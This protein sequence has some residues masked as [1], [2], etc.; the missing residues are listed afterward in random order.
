MVAQ[1]AAEQTGVQFLPIVVGVRRGLAISWAGSV[2]VDAAVALFAAVSLVMGSAG[3]A[4]DQVPPRHLLDAAAQ[5]ILVLGGAAL[6]LRRRWPAVFFG[7]EVVLSS[8]YLARGYPT[9][10]LLI[11]VGVAAFVFASRRGIWVTVAGA[12]SAAVV[13]VVADLV[14]YS[15]TGISGRAGAVAQAGW[16]IVPAVIGGLLR[17]TRSARARAAEQAAGRRVEQ[18]RL[19]MEREVHDVVG[20]GLSVISLQAGVALHVLSRRPEH[21]RSALEAIRAT[22]REALEELRATLA[23]SLVDGART[24]PIGLARVAEIVQQVRAAGLT[25]EIDTGGVARTVPSEVDQVALRVVQ[26]SL[27]NVL[28]HAGPATAHVQV[29][30]E[31][32]RLTVSVGDDG[33][34]ASHGQMPPAGRGLTGLRQRTVEL[35]G[36]FAAGPDSGGGWR[37]CAVLP[38]PSN[39]TTTAAPVGRR[40]SGDLSA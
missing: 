3:A 5:V 20:H 37:V 18:E 6:L 23:T 22:S 4:V 31:P 28:R 34:A 40:P 30:Y 24:Y 2:W 33:K 39:P 9:G 16:V 38:A 14:G 12:V 10:P 27:T 36:S 17:E 29:N 25:V 15:Q 21:A 19:R 35:G 1:V 32:E 8:V 13:L 26:E 11:M 7:S